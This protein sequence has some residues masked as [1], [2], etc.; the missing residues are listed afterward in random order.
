MSAIRGR[1]PKDRD[2]AEKADAI[3][4]PKAS[5]SLSDAARREDKRDKEQREKDKKERTKALGM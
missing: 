5:D 4:S 3:R 1:P 2:A